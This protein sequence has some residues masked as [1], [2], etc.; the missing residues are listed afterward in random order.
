[1]DGVQVLKADLDGFKQFL[2]KERLE[3]FRKKQSGFHFYTKD[4]V[5]M[6]V[7]RIQSCNETIMFTDCKLQRV[8]PE[9]RVLSFNVIFD[10][11]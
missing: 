2:E 10:A 8:V 3:F 9:L 11:N 7:S 6:Y 1:M 5:D 4:D